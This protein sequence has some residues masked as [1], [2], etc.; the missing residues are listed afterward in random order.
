VTVA[1][2]GGLAVLAVALAVLLVAG[3]G[4]LIGSYL[5]TQDALERAGFSSVKVSIGTGSNTDTVSVSVSVAAPPNNDDVHQVAAIVW[6]DF[7]QRFGQLRVT[8]HGQ[9]PAI[10]RTLS[11]AELVALLGPRNPAYDATTVTGSA[12]HLGLVVLGVG[13]ALVA[14]AVGVIVVILR[15]RR[16]R[17]EAQAAAAGSAPATDW[18]GWG[19]T[20]PWRL[21]DGPWGPPPGSPPASSG[22]RPPWPAPAGSGE[23]EPSGPGWG[24][25]ASAEPSSGRPDEF[26]G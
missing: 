5:N 2:K 1:R 20:P 21:G 3:C 24:A 25:P 12:E 6:Q 9:G 18:T 13:L 23:Q 14:V 8:V 26:S 22:S 17:R 7:R 4:G 15:R 11:H 10:Q 19:A 16:R